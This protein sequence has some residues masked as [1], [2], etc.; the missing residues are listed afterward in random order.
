MI[1]FTVWRV[2]WAVIGAFGTAWMHQETG[3]DPRMGGVIGLVV[4]FIFGPF[5]LVMFWL[6]LYY[7]RL[8]PRVITKYRRWYEW[9]KP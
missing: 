4:G 8:A 6:W 2:I 7:N 1:T 3:R 9:W 5:F